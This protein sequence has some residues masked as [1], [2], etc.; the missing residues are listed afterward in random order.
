MRCKV[1][2]CNRQLDEHGVP[3][4]YCDWQQGRCPMQ[5]QTLSTFWH[6]VLGFVLILLL[7]VLWSIT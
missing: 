2:G 3:V 6:Y 1:H 4:E 7:L 5:K